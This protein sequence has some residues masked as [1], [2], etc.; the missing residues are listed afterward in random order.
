MEFKNK[1]MIYIE[2]SYHSSIKLLGQPKLALSWFIYITFGGNSE[3]DLDFHANENRFSCLRMIGVKLNV[4]S[5]MGIV[6][7]INHTI[8]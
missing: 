5:T 4:K 3:I 8:K 7:K 2:M 6:K 1:K